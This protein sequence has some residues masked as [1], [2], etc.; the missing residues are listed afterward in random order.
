MNDNRLGIT[1]ALAVCILAAPAIPWQRDACGSE[2][3]HWQFDEGTGTT[4]ADSSGNSHDG[5]LTNGV[6]W[7]QDG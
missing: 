5:T 3:A 1:L 4:T 2:I 6:S 7:T